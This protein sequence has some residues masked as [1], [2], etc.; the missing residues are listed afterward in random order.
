MKDLKVNDQEK[1]ALYAWPR[2]VELFLTEKFGFGK[3]RRFIY[4]VSL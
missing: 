2:P 4:L 3:E 1:Y